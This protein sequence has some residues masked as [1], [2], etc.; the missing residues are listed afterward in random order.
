[1]KRNGF[2]L[3]WGS[4]FRFFC[5]TRAKKGYAHGET[6]AQLQRGQE[7]ACRPCGLTSTTGR[8]RDTPCKRTAQLQR[9]GKSVWKKKIPHAIACHSNLKKCQARVCL[10]HS[11]VAYCRKH[12]RLRYVLRSMFGSIIFCSIS[13]RAVPRKQERDVLLRKSG[14]LSS[15]VAS[16]LNSTHRNV[17][18]IRAG[19]SGQECEQ[20]GKDASQECSQERNARSTHP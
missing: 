6:D 9:G 20:E 11:H 4:L 18:C 13:V 16:Q 7:Y 3:T 10:A 2:L 5:V 1:M 17:P 19:G 12:M 14:L 15:G 8:R